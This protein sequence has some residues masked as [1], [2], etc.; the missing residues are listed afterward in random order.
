MTHCAA[1]GQLL[2]V[3]FGN[4]SRHTNM[5]IASPVSRRC[6]RHSH[7]RQRLGDTQAPFQPLSW[8]REFELR[9]SPAAATVRASAHNPLA[10]L[11]LGR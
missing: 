7:Y 10:D 1:M 11:V 8:Y 3:T 6:A 9:S 4:I 5:A 2:W